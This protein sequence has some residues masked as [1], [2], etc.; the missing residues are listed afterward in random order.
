LRRRLDRFIYHCSLLLSRALG[1]ARARGESRGAGAFGKTDPLI[2]PYPPGG[3]SDVVARL[4]GQKP[5]GL[6][7]AGA[8]SRIAAARTAT[9]APRS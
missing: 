4:V 7:A 8:S 6:E 1:S 3:T 2:V 5:T 9:S